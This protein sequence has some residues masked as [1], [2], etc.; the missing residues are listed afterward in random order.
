MNKDRHAGFI[1]LVGLLSALFFSLPIV[2]RIALLAYLFGALFL[3]KT[4]GIVLPQ[5][6]I[7]RGG[8]MKPTMPLGTKLGIVYHP[9]NIQVGDIVSFHN[10]NTGNTVRHRI[11]EMENGK[12]KTKGDRNETADGWF[13]IEWIISKSLVISGHPLYLPISPKALKET[14][15]S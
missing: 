5:P 12:V 1:I 2:H 10:G 15:T 14:L 8:S 9:I 11:V 6:V 3:M 4:T 7:M 13:P